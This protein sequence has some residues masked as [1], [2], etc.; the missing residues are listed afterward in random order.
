[1]KDGKGRKVYIYQVADNEVCM[2]KFGCQAVVA[3]T[4][5]NAVLG[6][7]LINDGVWKGLGVLGPE[8]LD[9]IPFMD[10]M[11]DYGFPFGIKE[12]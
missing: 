9:P 3:Q 7:E 5:F 6:W 12:M 4:A 10:K 8:A 2:H 11:S 1:M